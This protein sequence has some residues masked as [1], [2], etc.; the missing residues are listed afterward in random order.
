MKTVQTERS[1]GSRGVKSVDESG[2]VSQRSGGSSEVNRGEAQKSKKS[3]QRK[4][5]RG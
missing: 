1:G 5:N 3:K 4:R 2:E